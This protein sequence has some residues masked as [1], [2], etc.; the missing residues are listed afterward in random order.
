MWFGWRQSVFERDVC[1]LVGPPWFL[2]PL[3]RAGMECKCWP[4]RL[5]QPDLRHGPKV[6]STWHHPMCH[7]FSPLRHHHTCSLWCVRI[8][9]GEI[10]WCQ[11][12]SLRRL[13]PDSHRAPF[14]WKKKTKQALLLMLWWQSQKTPY[15][16]EGI[17]AC[18]IASFSGERHC[19]GNLEPQ[20]R[21]NY[22]L[23]RRKRHLRHRRAIVE[24]KWVTHWKTKEEVD[25]CGFQGSGFSIER[26]APSRGRTC[27]HHDDLAAKIS[28]RAMDAMA[29]IPLHMLSSVE[30][31]WSSH[32]FGFG[33]V[34][35]LHLLTI[36]STR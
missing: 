6:A 2:S 30:I 24:G 13:L 25:V 32:P 23:G 35:D 34:N 19:R 11:Q 26:M 15:G 8:P 17:E 20:M 14:L 33:T 7:P 22:S 12:H 10:G 4:Q 1:A 9:E 29:Y 31:S 18:D 27:K 21:K 3:G 5:L 28:L 16:M 36:L